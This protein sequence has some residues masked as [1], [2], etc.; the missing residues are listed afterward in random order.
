MDLLYVLLITRYIDRK[1][2][3]F[4]QRSVLGP[5]HFHN[6]RELRRGTIGNTYFRFQDS[7]KLKLKIPIETYLF[8]YT[9]RGN[10]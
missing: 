2:F 3:G 5:F 1:Y 4:P 6:R 7:Q 9:D 8:S 10:Y